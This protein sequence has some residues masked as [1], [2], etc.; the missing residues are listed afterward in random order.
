[1]TKRARRDD[2]I[3]LWREVA[4]CDVREALINDCVKLVDKLLTHDKSAI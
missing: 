3:K 2:S 1:M 4:V